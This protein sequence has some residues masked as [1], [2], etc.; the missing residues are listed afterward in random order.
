MNIYLCCIA[1]GE[2]KYIRDFVSYYKNIGFTRVILCDNNYNGE[3]T[4]DEVLS[5]F[6][7]S[8]FVIIEDYRNRKYAQ[9]SSYRD[10][11]NK[12]A[13]EFDW[14]AFFDC[15]EFLTLP[16]HSTIEDY[17]SQEKFNGFS[18]IHLNWLVYGDDNKQFYENV[19]VYERFNS[20]V[21]DD[22]KAP[23]GIKHNSLVKTILRSNVNIE[24]GD[25]PNPHTPFKIYGRVCNEHGI[26]IENS[27]T[28]NNYDRTE[29]YLRHYTTKSAEEYINGK[30]KY[31]CPDLVRDPITLCNYFFSINSITPEKKKMFLEALKGT[32]VKDSVIEIIYVATGDY[33]KFYKA[34]IESIKYFFPFVKKIVKIITNRELEPIELC[35]DIIKFEVI[36]ILDLFYPCIN[37]HKTYFIKQ[38]KHDEADYIFYFDADSVFLNKPEY[39]WGDIINLMNDGY[40]ITGIHPYYLL[41]DSDEYKER[42]ISVFFTHMTERNKMSSAYIEEEKYTYIISSFF[43]GKKDT[44]LK[45]CDEVNHMIRE[46]MIRFKGYHIPPYI[47]ENYFNKIVYNCEHGIDNRFKIKVGAYIIL[48]GN[49]IPSDNYQ[50]TFLAQKNMHK[51]FKTSRQ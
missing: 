31:G 34:F 13:G 4:F 50:E 16:Q 33:V 30:F 42:D 43:G 5:D 22:C 26:E 44:M 27:Y 20:Y 37:L 18:A 7:E 11:Y 8:G 23:N 25:L 45:M 15:D 12:Y 41:P 17:L 46:D 40:F 19:P 48:G 38:L 21:S 14:M 6:I 28:N 47:D 24:L 35:D 39:F 1:R 3:E 36:N 9:I 51:E 2:N 49:N 32:Y 29:A 10:C